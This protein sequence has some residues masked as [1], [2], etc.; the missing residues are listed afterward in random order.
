[1]RNNN[2]RPIPRIQMGFW[3]YVPVGFLNNKI[4]VKGG[5]SHGWLN[6]SMISTDKWNN[7]ENLQIH[8]K[9]AYIRLGGVKMLKPY[10]GLFHGALMGGTRSNG[11]EIPID[12][13][14]TFFGG[15]SEK[16]GEEKLQ[17]Q[18]VRTMASGI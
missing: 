1:M 13:L 14:A 16:I 18:Q 9:W 8:E 7:V 6:D 2:S 5:I 17:M 12:Y 3:N 11:A 15:G 4:E 10:I